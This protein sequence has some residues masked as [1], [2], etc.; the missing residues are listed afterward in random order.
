M[1]GYLT[2]KSNSHTREREGIHLGLKQLVGELNASETVFSSCLC[3]FYWL[4]I[5]IAL[6]K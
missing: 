4:L 1:L 5:L 2:H 6:S 3:F